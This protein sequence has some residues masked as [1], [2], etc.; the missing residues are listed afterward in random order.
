MRIKKRDFIFLL[1]S[2]LVLIPLIIGGLIATPTVLGAINRSFFIVELT[3]TGRTPVV[4]WVNWTE[5]GNLREG[6]LAALWFTFNV[7]DGDGYSDLDLTKVVINITLGGDGTGQQQAY[8]NSNCNYTYYNSNYTFFNCTVLFEYYSNASSSWVVNI[9]VTDDADLSSFNDTLTFTVNEL[10]AMELVDPVVNFSSV[11]AGS[12]DVAA[13]A[14]LLINNTGNYD[15]VQINITSQNLTGKTDGSVISA[16]N[17]TVNVTNA[18]GIPMNPNVAV[19]IPDANLTHRLFEDANSGNMSMY[20]YIDVPT[21]LT[22]QI[23][24]V[25]TPWE[26]VL[27]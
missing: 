24:N 1:T 23:F 14:P 10:T 19:I 2:L 18:V 4:F 16:A 21:G 22:A 9:S 25:T 27:E 26:I 20:F 12:N 5:P 17:I 11:S 13:D 8:N 3:M 6:G 7:S 15:F